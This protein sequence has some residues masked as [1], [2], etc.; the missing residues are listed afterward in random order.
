MQHFEFKLGNGN[1]GDSFRG[2]ISMNDNDSPYEAIVAL[3]ANRYIA[4]AATRRHIIKQAHVDGEAEFSV[5]LT[6]YEGRSGETHFGAAWLTASLSPIHCNVDEYESH[7][8]ST[9]RSTLDNAAMSLYRKRMK[10]AK[11][12]DGSKK[13][14]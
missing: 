1:D 13:Y 6:V 4:G 3:V 9:L 14:A 5:N 11:F 10:A 12:I 2:V 7:E 8:V